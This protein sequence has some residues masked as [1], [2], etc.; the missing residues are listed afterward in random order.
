[1]PKYA[2]LPARE[3]LALEDI[4]VD[5]SELFEKF[6]VITANNIIPATK[7]V[8]IHAGGTEAPDAV[9]TAHFEGIAFP[10]PDIE[11]EY[12]IIDISFPN[13]ASVDE[14][15]TFLEEADLLIMP[16]LYWYALKFG[17]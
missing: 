17:W 4:A 7:S 5:L 3:S 8:V 1:V 13:G 11:V 16:V 12:G 6:G 15:A 14:I 2:T 10:E 9:V